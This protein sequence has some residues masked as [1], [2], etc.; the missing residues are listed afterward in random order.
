MHALRYVYVKVLRSLHRRLGREILRVQ[1]LLPG[2][3]GAPTGGRPRDDVTELARLIVDLRAQLGRDP[4]SNET[5]RAAR[6]AWGHGPRRLKTR[7]AWEMLG[8]GR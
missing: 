4:T 3:G 7:R 5:Y 1:D 6:L 2:H 8:E